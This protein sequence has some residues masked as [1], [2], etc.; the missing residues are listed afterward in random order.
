MYISEFGKIFKQKI[1]IPKIIPC[2]CGA[3]TKIVTGD[4]RGGYGTGVKVQCENNH[5]FSNFCETTNR[6]IHKWNNRM[7][8]ANWL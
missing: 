2:K 8:K 7:V 6:A 3:K 1:Y 4:I 5:S